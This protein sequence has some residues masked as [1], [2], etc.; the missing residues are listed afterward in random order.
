MAAILR[1][2]FSFEGD[3]CLV[4]LL[5]LGTSMRTVSTTLIDLTH[6]SGRASALRGDSPTTFLCVDVCNGRYPV[7]SPVFL[8]WMLRA[9]NSWKQLS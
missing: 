2:R 3:I 9:Q 1:F 8:E 7:S 4:E 5:Y 6:I